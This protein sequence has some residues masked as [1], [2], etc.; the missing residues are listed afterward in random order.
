MRSAVILTRIT[1]LSIRSSVNF[2]MF[3]IL[4]CE[5]DKMLYLTIDNIMVCKMST[6][7]YEMSI[8]IVLLFVSIAVSCHSYSFFTYS[9]KIVYQFSLFIL[10][11]R[12][13][14]FSNID[15]FDVFIYNK[16][17]I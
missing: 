17:L 13:F 16:L 15:K 12:V 3:P 6:L 8:D 1:D 7:F 4:S 10:Y 2:I 14:P 11:Y 5:E 9:I